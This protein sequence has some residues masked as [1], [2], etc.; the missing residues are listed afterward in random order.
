MI[1]RRGLLGLF[2]ALPAVPSMIMAERAAGLNG[3]LLSIFGMGSQFEGNESQGEVKGAADPNYKPWYIN[4]LQFLSGNPLPEHV[5]QQI[6]R[7][8][9]NVSRFDPD[10]ASNKSFSLAA[11]M[12]IQQQREY[13]RAVEDMYG[14]LHNRVRTDEFEKKTGCYM[15]FW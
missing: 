1:G 9:R 15:N 3:G 6:R 14:R 8:T 7:K 13:D 10:L 5:V 4:T 11:K 12:R 2:G